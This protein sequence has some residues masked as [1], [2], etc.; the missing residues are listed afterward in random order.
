MR[1]WT[2]FGVML[3]WTLTVSWPWVL[4][5]VVIR[6]AGRLRFEEY[7]TLTATWKPLA[8]K[9]WR[10]STTLG[11]GIVY[12]DTATDDLPG[13]STRTE[14]HEVVH[15]RQAEDMMVTSF[16]VGVAVLL[17]VGLGT[18]AWPLAAGLG[19][20]LW[21]S[22]GAWQL[23][24]ILASLLRHGANA[25]GLYW[26]TEHERSARAQTEP[27]CCSPDGVRTWRE[28]DD[29]RRGAGRHL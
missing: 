13:P 27:W 29:L 21:W 11:R 22:G 17:A 28:H 26:S 20:G 16:L 12:Q 3:P 23:A 4:L 10:Y 15:V 2:L 8:A 18:R 7:G 9:L 24:G 25:D 6:A 14:H 5:M 19:A 1:R